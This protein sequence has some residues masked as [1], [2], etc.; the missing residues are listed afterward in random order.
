MGRGQ[1][2]LGLAQQWLQRI[3]GNW[4]SPWPGAL[5]EGGQELAAKD[6]GSFPLVPPISLP[7][8]HA[9]GWQQS[10]VG[11]WPL[12]LPAAILATGWELCIMGREPP[13]HQSGWPRW[14]GPGGPRSGRP[15]RRRPR[16]G[17][18]AWAAPPGGSRVGGQGVWV[19]LDPPP[20]PPPDPIK[21]PGALNTPHSSDAPPPKDPRYPHTSCVRP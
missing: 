11:H 8:Q 6:C 15:P 20:L 21:S 18:P 16:A 5:W 2:L 10:T 13:A 12:H 4:S 17:R 7:W 3:V 14:A 19:S 9:W 1:G